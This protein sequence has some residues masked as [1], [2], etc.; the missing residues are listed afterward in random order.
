MV[1]NKEIS[2]MFRKSIALAAL[3]LAL[4]AA[5]PAQADYVTFGYGYGGEHHHRP[6]YGPGYWGPPPVYYAPPPVYYY[7]PAPPPVVI[8]QQPAPVMVAPAPAPAPNAISADQASPS[9][10][11]NQGRTCREYQTTIYMNGMPKASYGTACLMSDG[12]WRIVN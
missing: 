2:A 1:G 3:V 10:T 12:Q 5:A 6:Y 11:D 8:Y 4:A 9:Y 7:E